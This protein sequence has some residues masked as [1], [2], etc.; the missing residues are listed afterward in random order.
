MTMQ[1]RVIFAAEASIFMNLRSSDVRVSR[2][3]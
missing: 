2:R 1:L 3:W